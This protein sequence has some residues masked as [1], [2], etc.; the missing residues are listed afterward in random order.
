[1]RPSLIKAVITAAHQNTDDFFFPKFMQQ[2][3]GARTE[4][5]HL[6]LHVLVTKTCPSMVFLI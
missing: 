2:Y 6:D 5:I 1:M 3:T 4:F